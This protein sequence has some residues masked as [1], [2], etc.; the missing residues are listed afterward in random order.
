MVAIE[1]LTTCNT[2]WF[3]LD[4]KTTTAAETVHNNK[5]ICLGAQINL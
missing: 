4:L 5:V 3:Q 2:E 1:L